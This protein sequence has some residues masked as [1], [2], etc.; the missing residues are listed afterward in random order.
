MHLQQDGEYQLVMYTTNARGQKSMPEYKFFT[1]DF[2]PNNVV[3]SINGTNL[4]LTWDGI[5]GADHYLVTQ[6]TDPYQTDGTVYTVDGNFITH[7]IAAKGFFNV[8]AQRNMRSGF[9]TAIRS[10]K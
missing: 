8:K 7:P 3:I 1:A 4:T 10:R 5:I 9:F 2:S 6:K